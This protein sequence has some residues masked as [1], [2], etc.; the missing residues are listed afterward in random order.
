MLENKGKPQFSV[1]KSGCSEKRDPDGFV[2]LDRVNP[3]FPNAPTSE[4]R[5]DDGFLVLEK[6]DSDDREQGF[7]DLL[8]REIDSCLGQI[9]E[10]RNTPFYDGQRETLQQI[11]RLV[12]EAKSNSVTAVP[13][14]PGGGKST[15]ISAMLY[16]FAKHF[17]DAEND[18]IAK[19]FGGIVVVVETSI[20]AHQLEDL[21]K[22]VGGDSVVAVVESVND[23]NL[24]QY[25]CPTGKAV[26]SSECPG[27]FCDSFESCPLAQA[28]FRLNETPILIMLHARYQRY[29]EDMSQLSIWYDA[30][31]NEHTRTLLVV[32]ELPNLFESNDLSLESFRN[33]EAELESH[34]MPHSAKARE[35]LLALQQKW[36][37]NVRVPFLK[38]TR[39]LVKSQRAYGLV[40]HNEFIAAGFDQGQ[41]GNLSKTLS[42]RFGDCKAPEIIDTIL[43]GETGFFS[44]NRIFS[45]TMPRLKKF[46]KRSG[47]ATIVFSGT[48][49]LT[50]ELP[51]SGA[52]VID[53]PLPESYAHL[54]V[55]VQHC[56]GVSAS[57]VAMSKDKNIAAVAEW[58]KNILAQETGG[59]A[60]VATYKPH[61]IPL[62]TALGQAQNRVIPYTDR[63]GRQEPQLPY[64]GGMNGS[65]VYSHTHCVICAGLNRFQPHEYLDRYIAM[66]PNENTLVN[67]LENGLKSLVAATPVM[68]LQDIYLAADIIQLVFRSALRNH[69]CTQPITLYLFQPPNGVLRALRSF[70]GDCQVEE[71]SELPESC[72]LAATANCRYGGR[73]TNIGKL[74]DYLGT[75]QD[76]QITPSEIRSATGLTLNQ[77]KEAMKNPTVKQLMVRRFETSGSGKNTI[78][79]KRAA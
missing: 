34:S 63:N 24:R 39:N 19:Y 75:I 15:C 10:A 60:L 77:Y 33:A 66:N 65:N 68:D 8:Q 53:A 23:S 64:F 25:G 7:K 74:L 61:S 32:D 5:D 47:F 28:V 30:Q 71:V 59:K 17:A 38:L 58:V 76:A 48:A 35:S 26:T 21:C 40:P 50:P 72:R 49:Q 27:R 37:W 16:V 67:E 20:E 46:D 12:L 79:K 52:D 78:Y 14:V 42:E 3:N 55:V 22:D 44:N 41:L 4:P 18:P 9:F 13:L 56:S 29:L 69:G 31:E 45:V 36:E 51:C 43:S 70:F 62:W 54:R 57:R 73:Q 2:V 11:Y 6:N 1:G